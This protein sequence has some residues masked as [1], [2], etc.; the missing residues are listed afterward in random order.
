[1][2]RPGTHHL[3]AGNVEQIRGVVAGRQGLRLQGAGI[4][5]LLHAGEMGLTVARISDGE[6]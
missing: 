6:A 4:L 5:Q 1:M 2:W 3:L